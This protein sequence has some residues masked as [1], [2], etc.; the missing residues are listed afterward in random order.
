MLGANY[1]DPRYKGVLFL[2]NGTLNSKL[3][4]DFL[5][6]HCPVAGLTELRKY[7]YNTHHFLENS[8]HAEEPDRYWILLKEHHLELAE[9]SLGLSRVPAI[10]PKIDIARMLDVLPKYSS[11]DNLKAISMTIIAND[12]CL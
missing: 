7:N 2:Q 9:F 4:N 6:K 5:N 8:V 3:F 10:M 11:D 1:L 12:V